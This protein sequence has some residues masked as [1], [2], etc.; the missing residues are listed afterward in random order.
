MADPEVRRALQEALAAYDAACAAQ[1]DASYEHLVN[2]TAIVCDPLGY[3]GPSHF[4]AATDPVIAR[5][6]A[7][8]EARESEEIA[9]KAREA[10]AALDALPDAS[11]RAAVAAQ[12]A[13]LTALAEALAAAT[14]ATSRDG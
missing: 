13:T 3:E 10:L 8:R 9:R 5:R 1:E 6:R 12:S 2:S 11:Y 4:D 14:P 7:A